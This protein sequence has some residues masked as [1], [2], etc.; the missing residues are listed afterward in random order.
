MVNEH[1]PR[2]AA[3][4]INLFDLGNVVIEIDFQRALA[5]WADSSGIP[6]DHLA[7]RFVLDEMYERHERGEID[8]PR[9]FEHLRQC[10]GIDLTDTQMARGWNSIY[11]GEIP[12]MR[13]L[14]EG[15]AG[16]SPIYAFTNTNETHRRCWE[17]EYAAVLQPFTEIFC[18]SRMGCRKPDPAAYR[19]VAARIG[20]APE[21]FVFFDD[22]QENVDGARA[23]GMQAILVRSIDDVRSAA[24]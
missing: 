9:Y 19:Q 24:G 17:A 21:A 22:L 16:R 18:S 14:L 11:V 15:L 5:A 12:G 8:A 20:A 3:R 23:A 6:A 4:Q 7:A 13:A 2:D 1:T 10:L